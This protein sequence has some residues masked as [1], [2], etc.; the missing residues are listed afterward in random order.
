MCSSTSSFADDAV[1]IAQWVQLRRMEASRALHR[2]IPDDAQ[3]SL[4]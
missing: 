1:V 4:S 3:D 2:P